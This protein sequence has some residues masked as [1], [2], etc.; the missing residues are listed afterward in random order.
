[1]PDNP[2]VREEMAA[3]MRAFHKDVVE[4]IGRPEMLK[5]YCH[6]LSNWV[7]NPNTDP[8]QIEMLFDEICLGAQQE[9][10]DDWDA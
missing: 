7:L 8:Y 2:R 10:L 4:K 9:G 5:V 1:M 6:A 3:R